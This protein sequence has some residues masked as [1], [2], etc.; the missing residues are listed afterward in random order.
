MISGHS[1]LL[2]IPLTVMAIGA[3]LRLVSITWVLGRLARQRHDNS[4]HA[5][6]N[7]LGSTSSSGATLDCH[8]L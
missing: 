7:E 3:V 4:G 1:G 5:E 2:S 6:I 8:G